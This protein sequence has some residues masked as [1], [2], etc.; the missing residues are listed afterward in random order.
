MTQE[1]EEA[2]LELA[3]VSCQTCDLVFIGSER[4][5][6]CPVCGGEPAGPYFQWTLE[7]AGLRLRD[8]AAAETPAAPPVAPEAEPPAVEAEAPPPVEGEPMVDAPAWSKASVAG[9]ML[10][11]FLVGE[12]GVEVDADTAKDWLL[13]LGAEPEAATIAVGRL[14]AVRELIAELTALSA[15][16]PALPAEPAD[17]SPAEDVPVA[18]AEEPAAP[19]P[20]EPPEEAADPEA[21]QE[22]AP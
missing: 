6:T 13:E 21:G 8:G 7:A 5:Q 9:A 12:R 1:T 10:A 15:E 22:P 2:P 3:L 4:R 18:Q 14:T 11:G 16:E 19:A 20:A 17:E